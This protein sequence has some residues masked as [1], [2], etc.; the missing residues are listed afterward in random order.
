VDFEYKLDEKDA[1]TVTIELL[2][3]IYSIISEI[4]EPEKKEIKHLN[5]EELGEFAGIYDDEEDKSYEIEYFNSIKKH[6]EF[7][8]FVQ[9]T[10]QL[11]KVCF[12]NYDDQ[13]KTAFFINVYHIL[14]IHSTI[15]KK[16]N[17]N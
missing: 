13:K 10:H 4:K 14:L 1:I 3:K 16:G 2:K 15:L 5:K 17:K 9:M 7:K 12:K 11:Q 6:K 8:N